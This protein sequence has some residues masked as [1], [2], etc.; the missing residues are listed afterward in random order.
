MAPPPVARMRRTCGACSSSC[1]ASKDGIVRQEIAPFGHPAA[2]AASAMRR[3]A[4]SMQ[5]TACGWGEKTM[6]LPAFRA[7]RDL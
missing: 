4:W 3:A 5:R 1:T 6:G 2:S 7:M